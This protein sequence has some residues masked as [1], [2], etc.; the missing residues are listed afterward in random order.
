MLFFDAGVQETCN[1][2]G[3]MLNIAM[4]EQMPYD[5]G[6]ALCL[7]IVFVA[8]RSAFRVPHVHQLRLSV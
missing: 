6:C 2:D 3:E 8:V 7:T 4:N 1:Y 5:F